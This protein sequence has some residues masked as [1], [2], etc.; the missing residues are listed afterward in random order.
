MSR[1]IIRCKHMSDIYEC[2]VCLHGY[3]F[4]K[5]ELQGL[6]MTDYEKKRALDTL[7]KLMVYRDSLRNQGRPASYV[8]RILYA[9]VERRVEYGDL[10]LAWR[11][12]LGRQGP[13]GDRG[14]DVMK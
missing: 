13:I 3:S 7:R 9:V 1:T 4:H 5:G 11:A 6:R 10:C 2:L 8:E 12:L 14:A